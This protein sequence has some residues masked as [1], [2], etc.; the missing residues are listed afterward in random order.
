[1]FLT[2]IEAQHLAIGLI[3]I[4]IVLNLM[5]PIMLIWIGGAPVAYLYVKARWRS[6]AGR[7]GRLVPQEQGGRGRFV[8][9]D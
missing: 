1:M 6:V 2:T 4:G 5:N 3:A 9:L 7:P 8:E